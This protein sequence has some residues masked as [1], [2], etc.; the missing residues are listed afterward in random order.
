MTPCSCH[1]ARDDVFVFPF[2]LSDFSVITWSK[3]MKPGF[4][5][6]D[7]GRTNPVAASSAVQLWIDQPYREKLLNNIQ[8]EIGR[9]SCRERVSDQV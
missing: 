3:F 4:V 8:R 5:V 1:I 6:L 7:A 9:A 2:P